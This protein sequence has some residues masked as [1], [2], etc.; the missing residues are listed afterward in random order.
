[1]SLTGFEPKRT[2]FGELITFRMGGAPR[3]L[4]PGILGSDFTEASLGHFRI[5]WLDLDAR[6]AQ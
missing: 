5:G 2:T 1:M 6:R 4:V 3:P